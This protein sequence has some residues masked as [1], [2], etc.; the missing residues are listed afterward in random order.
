MHLLDAELTRFLAA[1]APCC[2][3]GLVIC[4]IEVLDAAAVD[5]FDPSVVENVLSEN[6]LLR[7]GMQHFQH[8]TLDGRAVKMREDRPT[9]RHTFFGIIGDDAVRVFGQPLVPACGEL[10]VERMLALG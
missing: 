4:A 6:A 7:I 9:L 8:Q 2:I 1:F 3:D 5:R 10:L